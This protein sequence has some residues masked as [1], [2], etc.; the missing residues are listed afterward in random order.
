MLHCVLNNLLSGEYFL[1]VISIPNSSLISIL[2]IESVNLIGY[3]GFKLWYL[4]ERLLRLLHLLFLWIDSLT[5]IK[6]Y[7]VALV[8]GFSAIKI[9]GLVGAEILL[10]RYSQVWLSIY[11]L[12]ID[13]SLC[14]VVLEHLVI[15]LLASVSYLS[16]CIGISYENFF[17]LNFLRA[18][19]IFPLWFKL[20]SIIVLIL[21][22]MKLRLSFLLLT[23]NYG[24]DQL[25]N[26][27]IS[28]TIRVLRDQL[29]GKRTFF[30]ARAADL[31]F[32]LICCI[33]CIVSGTFLCPFLFQIINYSLINSLSLFC[34]QCYYFVVPEA[35]ELLQIEV[36]DCKVI[37]LVLNFKP[38]ILRKGMS[39]L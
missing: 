26:V 24:C 34:W 25:L 22:V 35:L 27:V 33:S 10:G 38:F 1:S 14:L 2:I 29:I 18:L 21:C 37:I 31:C 17:V 7:Q 19:N 4:H 15:N 30:L 6:V 23:T 5:H 11:L 8:F 9:L 16:R 28:L 36:I 3:A 32:D 20:W 12:Q 13:R 39:H